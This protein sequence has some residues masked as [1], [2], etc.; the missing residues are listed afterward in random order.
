M[1]F[2]LQIMAQK[3]QAIRIDSLQ[4]HFTISDVKDI[5]RYEWGFTTPPD[6]NEQYIIT[7]RDTLYFH[8]RYTGTVSVCVRYKKEDGKWSEYL[9]ENIKVK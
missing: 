6:Y 7:K 8:F 4:Y 1:F 3:I 9:N 5:V 2:S